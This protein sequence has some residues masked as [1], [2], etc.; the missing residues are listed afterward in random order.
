MSTIV[1][2]DDEPQ[3]RTLLASSLSSHGFSVHTAAG[4]GELDQVMRRTPVDLVLLDVMMPGEDGLSIC[5]R[6]SS[7]DGPPV[8]LLSAL[9]QEQDRIIGLEVGAGHYLSKPCSPREILATVRAALRRR[10]HE[11]QVER[12]GALTFLGWRIDLDA[13]QLFDPDG[14]LV[15]LT[16]G[17]FAVLRV[18]AERPRRV[19]SRETLLEAARGSD[20]ESYDRAIDVQVSRLRRKLR[21]NK[22]DLI[23]TVRNEGYLFTPQVVAG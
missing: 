20:T 21:G 8:I 6:I 3:I 23:R 13:H 2:V 5:R 12:R 4:G 11:R 16:D 22:D 15:D 1:I 18:F 9:N 10:R 7:A 17:E 14:V 19:L